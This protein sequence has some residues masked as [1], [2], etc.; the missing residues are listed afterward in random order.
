MQTEQAVTSIGTASEEADGTLVLMLRAAGPGG[1]VG[2]GV[3]RYSPGDPNYEA[4]RRHVGPIPKGKSVS[5]R[6]FP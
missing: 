4:V 3:K 2:D 6:P 5:V 1:A